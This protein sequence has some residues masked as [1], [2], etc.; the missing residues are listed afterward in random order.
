MK[1]E[2]IILLLVTLLLAPLA[3]LH[4][5]EFHVAL[6]GSDTNPGTQAQPFATITRARDAVRFLKRQ[7]PL[8]EPVEIVI[9]GGTYYLPET[10]LL[11]PRDSGT[12][13]AP[14]TYRAAEGEAVVLSGGRPITGPWEKE[15]GP[16]WHA[17]LP[18]AEESWNFRQLFVDGRREIRARY[19]KADAQPAYL[20]GGG[21]K[22]DSITVA[23]GQVKPSWG[24]AADAQVHV[25]PEWHFFN[26]LQTVV[27][28]GVP[29]S[30]IRLGP[31]EQHARITDGSWFFI[32]GVREELDQAR[33]WFLDPK[34][35]RL[36]YWPQDG[37]NPNQQELIAP[38]LNRIFHLR[39]DVN[40]GTHVEHVHLRGL[41][42]RHTT[43]T[44]G[45]IEAR[46][47]TDAAV[48]LENAS[49]CRIEQCRFENIGGYGLW[50]HLDSCENAIDT[51]TITD[52][53][54]GGVLLTSA[55]FSYMDDTKV[56]TPAR[57]RPK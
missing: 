37:R 44:L 28:V 49:H 57:P 42:F 30:I 19:P 2:L 22:K 34:A 48:M 31:A 14:V 24:E 11:E 55:R 4:A 51:N 43:Y 8:G 50:L 18:K 15:A 6:N 56:Y 25:V 36:D 32:E 41:V 17:D 33:E 52:A 35:R 12:E 38:R 13:S 27:G 40:A 16:I 26:Q 1:H 7:G 47:N 23:A 3:T 39:G 54:G 5:A 45:Q 46:V 53:G 20:F 9:H 29:Q 21:G 10:I